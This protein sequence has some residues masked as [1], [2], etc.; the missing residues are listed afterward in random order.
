MRPE[1]RRS[2]METRKNNRF[3]QRTRDGV[4]KFFKDLEEDSVAGNPRKPVDCCNPPES[5]SNPDSKAGAG[6]PKH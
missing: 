1:K 2:K 5:V 3:W 6:H 4:K